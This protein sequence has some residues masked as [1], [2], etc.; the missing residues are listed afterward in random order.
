MIQAKD[1]MLT[2]EN[3]SN[4]CPR[5]TLNTCMLNFLIMHEY[6]AFLSLDTLCSLFKSMKRA[7]TVMNCRVDWS[8]IVTDLKNGG[9]LLNLLS[10]AA[11]LEGFSVH[12]HP[13]LQTQSRN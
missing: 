10:E 3:W 1:V 5:Y 7:S 9:W 2:T 4:Y 6:N 8:L 13:Q 11:K 12:R